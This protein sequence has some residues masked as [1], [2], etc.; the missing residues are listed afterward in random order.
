MTQ[1]IIALYVLLSDG[2]MQFVQ[3]ALITIILHITREGE[4]CGHPVHI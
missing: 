3:L 2:I 4:L 1:C